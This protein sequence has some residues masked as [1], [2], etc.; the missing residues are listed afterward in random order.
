MTQNGDGAIFD[1]FLFAQVKISNFLKNHL[2]SKRIRVI[3]ILKQS[4]KYQNGFFVILSLQKL[5]GF[6]D[7]IDI[8]KIIAILKIC[9]ICFFIR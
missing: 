9:N 6:K 1:N 3:F 5:P 4:K 8:S 7:Y 2:Y